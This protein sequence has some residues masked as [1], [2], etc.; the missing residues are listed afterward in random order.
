[1]S[2]KE[3]AF[4]LVQDGMIVAEVSSLNREWAYREIWRYAGQYGQDGPV[5]IVE[6]D[7]E[8]LEP[9]A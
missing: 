9:L 8:T 1:M 4:G 2:E 6:L 5:Q 7:P 3:H